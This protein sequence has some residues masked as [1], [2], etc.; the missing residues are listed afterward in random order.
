VSRIKTP[1]LYSL[2]MDMWEVTIAGKYAFVADT[3]NGMFV[4]DVSD[5]GKPA[6]V[7]HRQL[8]FVEKEKKH[9]FVGGLALAKDH[10][11]V[12]GGYTDLHV[13]AAP[14]LAVPL[15]AE[16]DRAP[17]IPPEVPADD[18][19]FR[20]Y[21]PD[22]QVYAVAFA[23]DTALVAAGAAGLHA[24]QLSPEIKMLA[25]YATDGFAMD[26]KVLG[27]K[28]YVAEG[29]GGMSIW[30][31]KG[32]ASLECLGR[33]EVKGQSIKQVV[34]PAPGRYALLHVGPSALHIVDV[35]D[36]AHPKLALKDSRL[37]LLYGYQITDGLLDGRYASCFWHVT[38]FY[39][40]DLYGGPAP[41]YTGDN[42]AQRMSGENGTALIGKNMLVT[43]GGKYFLLSPKE[44]RPPEA[45][46]K[47]GIEGRNLDGK[48]SVFGTTLYV[49][50][51]YWGRVSRVDI[52]SLEA[53]KLL[54]AVDL[55]GNPGVVVEHNGKMVIP[56]GY[57]GLLVE[58]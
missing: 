3:F 21:K 53:P 32:D 46:P 14:G 25:E 42:Y 39:W 48:P 34:V 15:T 47:F 51:R 2:G 35:S 13:V 36:P 23:D 30:R 31:R 28:V 40:Y 9:S 56:A 24:V 19:Q 1:R 26:V 54:N 18:P 55:D 11:Y 12:A 38:G 50:N 6:F 58:R 44:T 37:G 41:V 29:K 33:Y 8:E 10:I 57:Q 52:S 27:D 49:S 45:L 22:G 43:Y 20:V 7:A 17:T 5:P 4:V 16:P